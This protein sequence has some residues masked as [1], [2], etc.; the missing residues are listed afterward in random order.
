MRISRVVRL[1][2]VLAAG[3]ALYAPAVVSPQSWPVMV[4]EGLDAVGSAPQEPSAQ[5]KR[6][7]AKYAE[8]IR[9]TTS[10]CSNPAL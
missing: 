3:V 7:I 10:S 9:V 8:V 6:E 2:I 4:K 1:P 5:I